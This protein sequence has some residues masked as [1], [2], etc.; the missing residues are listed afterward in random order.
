MKDVSLHSSKAPSKISLAYLS[1]VLVGMGIGAGGTFVL[2][3]PQWVDRLAEHSVVSP[4]VRSQV[5][6]SREE[7]LQ[8]R[9]T[10][11]EPS[12]FVVDVVQSTGPAVVR[13]NAQK[14]VKA[15]RPGALNDPFLERFFGSQMPPM[16]NEQIQ[17]GTGSGFIV[18]DDGKIFTNAHVVDG[19][20]EVTVTL[21]DGRTFPGRVMGSDP[22]T[23]VAV[24]KIEA[25]DLP[26]VSFADS[27]RLQVGEWAIAIGNPLGLDNTVTTGILS[28]TGR[29]SAE[30]GVPDKRVEFIQTDAAINP[31]NS[32][33][34]LLNADGKVIGMNTAIIQNAQGI[35]FAIPINK[36]QEIA[37]QLI[38]KGKAEHAYLGIQMA[39][40]TPELQSQ[41][42]QQGGLDI[43]VDK[44]VVIM[45][46]MPDSPAAIANLQ[47]GDVIESMQGE[48]VE[49]SEQVQ[50]L[51]AKLSVGDDLSLTVLRNGKQENLTATIGAL[52][53]TQPN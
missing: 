50:S 12:N 20:D 29:R 27:D 8:S 22:S 1:L 49:T 14:T 52:P 2:T 43:P 23:D 21:K 37:E 16:P 15:Q 34:P 3:N 33:G 45:K 41:L 42:R 35:G 24:V 47:Q 10:P 7:N 9:L 17:R 26:T 38:T 11:R 31:G 36:A 46:V 25:D 30:I 5:N 44:G 40:M 51:V 39:T 13:I 18:S 6:P 4:L 48:K 19:A 32:G 28:A 53:S